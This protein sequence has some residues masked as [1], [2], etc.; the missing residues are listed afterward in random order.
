M[1]TSLGID[2]GT[3]YSVI[4]VWVN[5]NPRPLDQN[6]NISIFDSMISLEYTDGK[7]SYTTAR[8][9]K[10]SETQ[11]KLY[12]AK[13]LIGKKYEE[14]TKMGT[15]TNYWSFAVVE[16]ENHNCMLEVP[17]PS[18]ENELVRFYPEEVSAM[19]LMFLEKVVKKEYQGTLFKQVVVTIPVDFS[20]AQRQATLRAC[21]LAGWKNVRL[22]NE[23]SA[24]LVA[25]KHYLESANNLALKRKALRNGQ[26]ALVIDFGGGTLDVCC[27]KIVNIQGKDE[28]VVEVIC[29]DGDADLGGKHFDEI[30]KRI[31]LR[32]LENVK[33][34]DTSLLDSFKIKGKDLPEE[35]YYKSLLINKLNVKSEELK[36][37]LDLQQMVKINVFDFFP[38]RKYIRSFVE[39]SREEFEEEC[40]KELIPRFKKVINRV[41][42]DKK[43]KA[44][45]IDLV[46]PIGGMCKSPFV[47]KIIEE[48][49]PE[50]SLRADPKFNTLTAV[51]NG[52]AYHAH[53]LSMEKETNYFK[54]ILPYSV[55]VDVIRNGESHIMSVFGKKGDC[56]SVKPIYD[57]KQ[58]IWLHED[59]Q[60]NAIFDIYI[61]ESR[62]TTDPGMKYM[63]GMTIEIPPN[64]KVSDYEMKMIMKISE[65]LIVFLEVK[66]VKDGK[67]L[68]DLKVHVDMNQLNEKLP[69]MM[70]HIRKYLNSIA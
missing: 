21:Q 16:D 66:K 26:V 56:L 38:E 31:F 3:T 68:G 1:I 50:E 65:D 67:H 37:N 30:I 59:N 44:E 45:N 60:S 40:R 51:A 70:K 64:T 2:L 15:E 18:D 19:V 48:M 34:F 58:R 14:Y 49:F 57:S 35:K 13:R 28:S 39:I 33:G 46:L 6:G 22:I 25:Y 54:E 5:D 55:G 4:S 62:K 61:G 7:F 27:G 63:G 36:I 11:S 42:N 47:M 9:A 12:D 8:Q 10:T 69:Q 53:R 20:P 29:T 43:V 24:S 17:D 41:L 32:K 52:A 23:P